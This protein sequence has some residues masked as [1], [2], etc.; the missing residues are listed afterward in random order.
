MNLLEKEVQD[1][2]SVTI[3]Y[4]TINNI[5]DD[6]IYAMN[7]KYLNKSDKDGE[8]IEIIDIDIDTMIRSLSRQSIILSHNYK[9][10]TRFKILM[11]TMGSIISNLEYNDHIAI[12]NNNNINV[13]STE[14]IQGLHMTT[15]CNI[16]Q[17]SNIKQIVTVPNYFPFHHSKILFDSRDQQQLVHTLIN[18]EEQKDI[19]IDEKI[20]NFTFNKPKGNRLNDIN[21]IKKSKFDSKKNYIVVYIQD[22]EMKPY[23]ENSLETIENIEIDD[24]IDRYNIFMEN[25]NIWK[26]NIMYIL[27]VNNIKTEGGALYQFNKCKEKI[28]IDF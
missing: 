18:K 27:S 28:K 22:N 2:L 11:L 16:L 7:K 24:I 6:I 12:L 15:V 21:D 14:K 19:K 17:D 8:I 9:C 20:F 26:R 23:I 13:V 4:A 1:Y 3:P 25:I 5:K 10:L